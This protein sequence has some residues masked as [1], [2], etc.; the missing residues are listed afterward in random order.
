M[1][2]SLPSEAR[3]PRLWMP[4]HELFRQE[5]GSCPADEVGFVGT[6]GPGPPPL[7]SQWK[8]LQWL[9]AQPL[10]FQAMIF[11]WGV[12]ETFSV[13][14]GHS[15]I[16]CL[17]FINL[18]LTFATHQKSEGLWIC[19]LCRANPT[20]SWHISPTQPTCRATVRS[21]RCQRCQSS[22]EAFGKAHLVQAQGSST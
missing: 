12:S 8:P 5:A 19:K 10:G 2:A 9:L 11:M 18:H 22:A 3:G 21:G 4:R 13:S 14:P 16:T 17:T 15:N 20:I 6:D 7:Q 1:I